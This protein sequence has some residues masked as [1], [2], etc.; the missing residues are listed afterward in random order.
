MECTIT[1]TLSVLVLGLCACSSGD[2][3]KTSDPLEDMRRDI[4]ALEARAEHDAE[5]V[6]V[7]HILIGFK[8]APRLRDVT[9]TLAEAE[10]LAADLCAR[11]KA[12]E[13]FGGLKGEYSDDSGRG[14]YPM[15]RASR[16]GMVPGFGNVGWRLEVGEVGVAPHHATKSPYG[17]HI[18]KRME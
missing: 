5:Q 17:W 1:F 9:R 2:M 4:A 12:G 13:D 18:I 16:G 15:T 7:S 11:I 10:Q 6:V 8:D 3:P 14:T